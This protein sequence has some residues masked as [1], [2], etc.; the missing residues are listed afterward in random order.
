[1]SDAHHPHIQWGSKHYPRCVPYSASSRA[2]STLKNKL[3]FSVYNLSHHTPTDQANTRMLFIT[4]LKKVSIFA[5]GMGPLRS[6]STELVF[7]PSFS[8]WNSMPNGNASITSKSR[9]L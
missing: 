5:D 2:M 1:M 7:S 6:K 8:Q 4:N 3:G 9:T